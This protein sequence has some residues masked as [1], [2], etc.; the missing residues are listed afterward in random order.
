MA[1]MHGSDIEADRCPACGAAAHGAGRCPAVPLRLE[2]PVG[3]G[4]CSCLPD[5]ADEGWRACAACGL[6]QA[7]GKA[8]CGY[9]GSRWV[10]ASPA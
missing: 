4:A 6:P 2:P 3:G 8:F 9:C 1:G 5:P 10:T 7:P